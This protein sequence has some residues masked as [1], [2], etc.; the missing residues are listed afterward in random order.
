MRLASCIA[1]IESVISYNCTYTYV[2]SCIRVCV[3]MRTPARSLIH[4]DVIGSL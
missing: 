4:I 2:R 3:Y 1:C